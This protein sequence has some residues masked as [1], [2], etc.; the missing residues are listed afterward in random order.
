MHIPADRSDSFCLLHPNFAPFV[1]RCRV[2]QPITKATGVNNETV[3]SIQLASSQS[4]C[5]SSTN[6][7]SKGDMEW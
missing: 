2:M 7:Y 6:V 3:G 1:A 4:Y 5:A